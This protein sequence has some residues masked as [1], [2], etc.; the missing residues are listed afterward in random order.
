MSAANEAE[1]RSVE[2]RVGKKKTVKDIPY[3]MCARGTGSG[4]K[5]SGS[6]L[7]AHNL[8]TV[9][10]GTSLWAFLYRG[11]VILTSNGGAY[12]LKQSSNNICESCGYAAS[13]KGNLK[14]HVE[15]VHNKVRNHVC[16]EC[17]YATLH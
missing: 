11:I 6:L 10:S 1:G 3:F 13:E 4:T 5:V 17:G 15:Q 7:S 8:T 12:F 14:Q 2:P 9:P 16:G